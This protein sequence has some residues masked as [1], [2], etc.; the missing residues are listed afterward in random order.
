MGRPRK[1]RLGEYAQLLGEELRLQLGLEISRSI[2]AAQ[3]THAN[4][5]ASLRA[6]LRK[7]AREIDAMARRARSSRRTLGRWVPGGPGR[8][9]KDAH[10]RIAAFESRTQQPPPKVRLSRSQRRAA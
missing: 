6:E 5:L 4:E 3:E 8:P 10:D 1:N 9:P 2:A 7:L